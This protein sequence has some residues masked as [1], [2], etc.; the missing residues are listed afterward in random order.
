MIQQSH[1]WGY[2]YKKTG[3]QRDVC[4]PTFNAAYSEHPRYRNSIKVPQWVNG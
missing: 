1:F 2:M 3:Y 4:T